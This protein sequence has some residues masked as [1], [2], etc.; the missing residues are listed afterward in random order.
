[1]SKRP[2]RTTGENRQTFFASSEETLL[3]GCGHSDDD[4]AARCHPAM[5]ENQ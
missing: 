2:G 1:M 5:S 3:R 4:A